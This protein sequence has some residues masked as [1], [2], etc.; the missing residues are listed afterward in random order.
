[1]KR[2]DP[3]LE[4]RARQDVEQI[5]RD[6]AEFSPRL[7]SREYN[8]TPAKRGE[9]QCGGCTMCC[10]LL[11]VVELEKPAGK[12]CQHCSKGV[13]CQVYHVRPETCQQFDCLWLIGAAPDQCRPD[14]SKCVLSTTGE[15]QLQVHVDPGTPDAWREGRMGEFIR[16]ALTHPAAE[17]VLIAIGNRRIALRAPDGEV[18]KEWYGTT[19]LEAEQVL[20]PARERPAEPFILPGNTS[21]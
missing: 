14:K 20:L 12:W 8:L 13:G 21:P 19:G 4:E 11:A 18:V 5:E 6:L 9:R 17:H 10:K 7:A 16:A 15:G 2:P 3:K 1:V